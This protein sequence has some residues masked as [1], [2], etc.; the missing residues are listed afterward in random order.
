M[1]RAVAL[2]REHKAVPYVAEAI[3]TVH[4]LQAGLNV[5]GVEA[6]VLGDEHWPLRKKWSNGCS[7]GVV[8]LLCTTQHSS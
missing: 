5:A 4:R 8:S 6:G 3:G 1:K 7:G 2:L